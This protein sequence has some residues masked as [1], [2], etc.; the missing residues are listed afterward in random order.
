M[1]NEQFNL[2]LEGDLCILKMGK[3]A[4]QG[5]IPGIVRC[6]VG[7][8]SSAKG[9]NISQ[10][11]AS[12]CS[13]VSPPG[14]TGRLEGAGVGIIVF[15]LAC[16]LHEEGDSEENRFQPGAKTGNRVFIK[17]LSYAKALRTHTQERN[18]MK[19]YTST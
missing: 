18:E 6:G 3:V 1:C 8:Q 15:A 4:P 9:Q 19:R 16:E 17:V 12:R 2:V 11:V 5:S 7:I 13:S 10:A 14:G